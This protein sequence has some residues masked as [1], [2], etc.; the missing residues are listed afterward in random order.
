MF[1]RVDLFDESKV[2]SSLS[3]EASMQHVK[4]IQTIVDAGDHDKAHDALDQLLS[5]GPK[6][7]QALKLR[8]ALFEAEGRFND[9]AK[10]WHR[11]ATIDREDPDA[12]DYFLRR[13]IEDREHFYFTDDLP[14]GERRFMA[15]PKALIRNSALGLLGC[16]S[17]L[18]STRFAL[19][20][21]ILGEP[22]VMLGLFCFFVMVPWVMIASV[23]LLSLKSITVGID[24]ITLATRLKS[25]SLE[26]KEVEKACLA[27][28]HTTKGSQLTLVIVPKDKEKKALE[29]DLNYHSSPIRARSY[30]VNE[31]SR[32][33]EVKYT[34]QTGTVDC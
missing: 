13:Q 14:G 31:I 29:V 6:N 2:L 16:L 18:V 19:Y 25:T 1:L 10:V 3:D 30:L 32:H 7:T 21:P 8:A 28:K 27:R 33:V 17:F 24:R 9:E 12:V 15:Y 11:I 5:L 26:W 22:Q 23:Y 34:S 20:Y 4:Q